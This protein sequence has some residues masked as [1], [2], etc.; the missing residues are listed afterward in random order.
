MT[1]KIINTG[2]ADTGNGDPIRTAFGKVNDNFTELYTALG[3]DNGGINLGAF[4]FTGSTMSTTDSSAIVIDQAVTVASELTMQGDIVPNIANE[5]NLGSAA[6][7]WKSLY[8][9]NNTIYIGG[10][11]LGVDNNGSLT[12]NG[13]TVAHADGEFIRLDALTDVNLGSPQAGDVLSYQGGYWTAA[14]VDKLKITD[15]VEVTLVGGPGVADP[16][17]TF[18]A[19]TGGDQLQIQGAEVSTIAGNLALTSVTDI[20]IIS[21]GSGA[22][23]GGSKNWTFSADGS[24]TIP[25]D[26]RSEGNINIDINLSD[27]TLRRWQFGEDGDLEL[28][29]DGGIVFDRADTTIRVGMGFHIA[30]GEGISLDAIDQ[31]AIL[32]LS[33]AGNGPVNQTYNKTNLG[34]FFNR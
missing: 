19:I 17:V 18:P 1:Q 32:T 7:P 6:R 5:H 2:T 31:T 8:V 15:G 33:G 29:Q 3:L 25:G 12:W 27:S 14:T 16:F 11:S 20:N 26:I 9:S 28:P 34:I 22:A 4:E 21:N 24:V 23:P 30:S 13:S 10:N